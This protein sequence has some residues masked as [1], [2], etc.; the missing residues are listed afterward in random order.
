MH[1]TFES[2]I[3]TYNFSLI[4]LVPYCFHTCILQGKGRYSKE[5]R[6]HLRAPAELRPS[7]GR[8]STFGNVAPTPNQKQL[9]EPK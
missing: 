7:V 1:G 8:M 3:A 5:R 2:V 9:F 6:G 4:I